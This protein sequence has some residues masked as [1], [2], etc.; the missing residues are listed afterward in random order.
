MRI[1]HVAL[2]QDWARGHADGSYDIS[3][4][5]VSLVDEGF[6]H[7]STL[8]QV[9]PVLDRYFA[10]VAAVDLL[11]IDLDKLDHE[12][13]QVLWEHVEGAEDPFPH[14]YGVIPTQTV[15]E[16]VRLEH[17]PGGPWPVLHVDDVATGP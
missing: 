7:A 3:T 1:L 12:G 11:V 2:P 15:V 4:R 10:D 8:A 17:E 5:G 13:A 6:I 14:V 16:V 9:G